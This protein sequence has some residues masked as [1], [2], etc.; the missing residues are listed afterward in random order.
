M[1]AL[2]PLMQLHSEFNHHRSPSRDRTPW[3][4]AEQTGDRRVVP[5]FRRFVSLRERLVPYLAE[6][7][8]S[9]VRE[10]KPLMRAL[11]FEH[12]ADGRIWDFPY[13]YLLGDDLLVAPVC[14]EGAD[15]WQVYLPEGD[16]VDAWS[17]DECATGER[18]VAAPI[19]RVPVFCRAQRAAELVPV[20]SDLPGVLS[21]ELMEV[22]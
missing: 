6:S 8:R 16:W 10:R 21:S 17:G 11:F 13:Q 20:F 12:A 18:V 22:S 4:I 1:A 3:N 9:A 5:V 2:C 19:D 7:G 14:E 15:R